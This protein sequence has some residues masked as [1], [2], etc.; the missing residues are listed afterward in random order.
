MA[1]HLSEDVVIEILPWLPVESL[2]RFKSVCKSWYTLITNSAFITQH[3]HNKKK[4]SDQKHLLVKYCPESTRDNVF[5]LFSSYK[6][7]T[8]SNN[9]LLD[10]PDILSTISNRNL[11]HPEIF[12]RNI[13]IVGSCNGLVCLLGETYIVV[14]NPAIR[15]VSKLVL[16]PE[17][18]PSPHYYYEKPKV[19]FSVYGFGFDVVTNDYK[20]V[21][22]LKFSYHDDYN[23]D[24]EGNMVIEVYNLGSD[25]WRKIDENQ[26]PASIMCSYNGLYDC[27]TTCPNYGNKITISKTFCWWG[28]DCCEAIVSFDMT[29]ETI[30]QT[31]MPDDVNV[32]LRKEIYS[33]NEMGTCFSILNDYVAMILFPNLHSFNKKYFDIWVLHEFGAKDSWQKLFRVGPLQG[34]ERVLGFWNNSNELLLED[35]LGQLVMYRP[36]TNGAGGTVKLPACITLQCG[37]LL[38]SLQVITYME[39]LVSLPKD[40][41]ESRR[42]SLIFKKYWLQ[43]RD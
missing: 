29:T 42:Q 33:M 39:S 25:S 3:L 35:G 1:H 5:S 38:R 20:V 12:D 15:E 37:A 28:H 17:S 9:Q 6:S 43:N 32:F 23:D 26:V 19:R 31:F 18:A 21:R 2:L 8:N 14:W 24:Y 16:I 11:P 7:K 4:I 10:L 30:H 13:Q 36:T 27:G 40:L 41:N 34:I 22:M